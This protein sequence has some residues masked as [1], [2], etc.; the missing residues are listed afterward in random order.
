MKKI[1]LFFNSYRGLAVFKFL[2]KK[3]DLKINKIV[4][5]KKFINREVFWYLKKKKISFILLGKKK[6]NNFLKLE[7]NSDL[8][9]FCGFPYIIKNNLFNLTKYGSLNLHAGKLPK[10]RGG[11]PLNW[12]I[13]NGEK[14]IGL[15]IIKMT[16]DIDAGDIVIEKSFKLKKNDNIFLVHKKA[17]LIFPKMTY[18]AIKKIFKYKKLKKQDTKKANYF[19]QRTFDDGLVNWSKQDSYQIYNFVRALT[20]PYHCAYTFFKRK[21]YFI[22][23]CAEVKKKYTLSIEPGNFFFKRNFIFVKTK[24]NYIKFYNKKLSHYIRSKKNIDYKFDTHVK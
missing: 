20:H 17:N 23:K 6:L 12:Q 22:S 21:I 5:A 10:Y 16:K 24:K 14:K 15:S 8:N 7:N 3:K 11:S 2:K 9:I 13:I 18:D 19:K 4:L 1:T